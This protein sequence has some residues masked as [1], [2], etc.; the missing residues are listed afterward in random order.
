[1]PFTKQ[2]ELSRGNILFYKIDGVI[3]EN[4]YTENLIP[5][6]QKIIDNGDKVCILCDIIDFSVMDMDWLAMWE[7][8]KFGFTKAKHISQFGVICKHKQIVRALKPFFM[9]IQFNSFSP[10][11]RNDAIDWIYKDS[12]VKTNDVIKLSKD[13]SPENKFGVP[14]F[15]TKKLLV[16]IGKGEAAKSTIGH[17]LN[18]ISGD[19]FDEELH[20]ITIFRSK[21]EREELTNVMEK[22]ISEVEESLGPR[23]E[24]SRRT[25][26]VSRHLLESMK[27]QSISDLI[28]ETAKTFSIDYII[29][30]TDH[31]KEINTL[32]GL[33]SASVAADVLR[34]A[35]CPVLICKPN[36]GAS[37]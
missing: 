1:M 31:A 14:F 13:Y 28:C 19:G 27:G 36:Q 25:L 30:G 26:R 2:E 3:K 6:M 9:G 32:S 35:P 16:A 7:D 37:F 10:N 24:K 21:D 5:E 18:L 8:A 22:A 20:L 34:D 11:E 17:A 23:S 33:F 15:H 29:M 12:S 4:D